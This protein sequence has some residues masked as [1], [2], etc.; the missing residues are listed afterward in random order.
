MTFLAE[1]T[2]LSRL[3]Q[4][5]ITASYGQCFADSRSRI[6]KEQQQGVVAFS[7]SISAINSAYDRA[8]LFRLQIDCRPTDCFFVANRENA[9]ILTCS[10]NILPQQMLYKT[11]HGRQP[12]VSGGS[13]VPTSRFDMI[14]ER[15]HRVGS[16][17][18]EGQISHG[19]AL[20]ICDEQVEE[21]ER[22]SVRSDGMGACSACVPQ[23]VLEKTF[24]QAEQRLRLGATHTLPFSDLVLFVSPTKSTA[25]EVQKLWG[26]VQITLGADDIDMT[27]I[28]RQPG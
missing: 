27:H 12:A 28:C 26:C 6:V 3:F 19:L 5:K 21:F 1:Q 20:L 2:H 4:P 9:S 18:I 23:I 22:V 13:G 8:S 25:S 16:D 10:R 7:V 14:Q 15:E 11:A 17:I 24:G